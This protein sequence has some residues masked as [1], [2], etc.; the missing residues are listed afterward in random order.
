VAGQLRLGR[1]EHRRRSRGLDPGS[2]GCHDDDDLREA[3]PDTLRYRIWT[4]VRHARHACQRVLKI[5][6][7]WP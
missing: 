5:S 1:R 7:D 2:L 6:P 4:P 3:D